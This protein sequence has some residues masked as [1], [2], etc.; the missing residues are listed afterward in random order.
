M[1]QRHVSERSIDS[2]L[3][4]TIFAMVLISVM[5]VF[6]FR[7]IRIGLLSLV[8]NFIPAIMSFGL[9]GYLV[10]TVG[11][12][13]SVV[14]AIV[15]GI[16]VDDTIHFLSDYLKARREGLPAAEAV[17]SAFHTVG[18]AL[19]TTTV[20]LSA[21]FMTFATSGFEVSWS[22]GLLVTMTI[23]LALATDFLLLPT[24]LMA[25]DRKA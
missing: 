12:A 19:L 14:V 18:Q 7:S 5:P 17:R 10:G 21:G 20:V 24:L 9:W 6:V 2:M 16:V 23:I 11:I 1:Q 3:S 25:I 15:F 13:S 8:P 4:G 22:L